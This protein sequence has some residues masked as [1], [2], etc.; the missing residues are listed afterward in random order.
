MMK[1]FCK[2]FKC[3]NRNEAIIERV[4]LIEEEIIC[5]TARVEKL[6]NNLIKLKKDLGMPI[7]ENSKDSREILIWAI[8][9]LIVTLASMTGALYGIV[10]E[11][12]L[13]DFLAYAFP[14]LAAVIAGAGLVLGNDRLYYYAAC[15]FV[16]A[17]L[18][19]YTLAKFHQPFIIYLLV[20]IA[21]GL[22]ILAAIALLRLLK[23][24]RDENESIQTVRKTFYP[25]FVII[26]VVDFGYVMLHRHD[27]VKLPNNDKLL[28]CTLKDI[29]PDKKHIQVK[30]E[31]MCNTD[32]QSEQHKSA[33]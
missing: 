25:L 21:Y 19:S 26:A 4:K 12:E 30:L 10:S 3:P 8:L 17:G 6:K 18:A 11:E 24:S 29:V 7:E 1:F 5:E 9:A 28:S 16:L 20:V 15:G 23:K 31:F 32:A 2:I 13:S 22:S 27:F 14:A 33:T